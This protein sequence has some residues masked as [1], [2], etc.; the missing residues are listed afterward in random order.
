MPLIK[1]SG[2]ILNS[3]PMGEYDRIVE[4]FTE[5]LGRIDGIAKGARSFKNR[6]GGSLEPFTHCSLG[7]FRKRYGSL[8]RIESADIINSFSLVREDLTL[9]LNSSR[10]VDVL[11]KL[12]PLEDPNKA[13]F[14]L[15]QKS[16]SRIVAGE[17]IDNVLFYYQIQILHISGFGLRFDGCVKCSREVKNSRRTI[18]IAEGGLVC[19][20]CLGR[21]GGGGILAS[22][23]AIAV[24][25]RWQSLVTSHINRFRLA[26][27]MKSE[28]K[29]ILDLYIG[30]VTGKKV[31]DIGR[32][33]NSK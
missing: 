17:L 11:R 8:Y 26:D 19:P 30:H 7:L 6:F 4:I 5:D 28:I 27:S 1:T 20:S 14:N 16:F 3:R 32:Y 13:I 23:G 25:C 31:L 22:G 12:T 9:L 2:I 18:S 24:M 29:G 10:M 21:V 33:V 15:L